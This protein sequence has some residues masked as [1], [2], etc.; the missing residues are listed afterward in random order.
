MI[1]NNKVLTG[2]QDISD[3]SFVWIYLLH[4]AALHFFHKVFDEVMVSYR[5]GWGVLGC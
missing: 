4:A 5:G 1:T 3:F 2:S